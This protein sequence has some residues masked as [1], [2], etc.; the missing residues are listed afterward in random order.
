MNTATP[1]VQITKLSKRF[2][3]TQAIDDID[4]QIH[5]G[6]IIGLLGANGCGKSTLLRHIIGL[7]LPDQGQCKTILADISHST[8]K[9]RIQL[10]LIL[11][12]SKAFSRNILKSKLLN[13]FKPSLVPIHTPK[14]LQNTFS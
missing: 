1:L 6:S 11:V 5:A 3:K 14:P 7:Y 10:S 12:E 13:R 2:G 9:S 8:N 4:L